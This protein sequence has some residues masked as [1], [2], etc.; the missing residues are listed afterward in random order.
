[1]PRC[2]VCVV[3]DNVETAALLCE[4][5]QSHNYDAVAVHS[6][7]EALALCAKQH[8]D[9]VLLDVCLP[10][11]DGYEVCQSLKRST[12]TEEIPVIFVTV[13]G[14]PTDVI[15]GFEMGAADY[16]TKPYNLPIVM[17]RVDAVLQKKN[18]HDKLRSEQGILLENSYTDQLTGLR[19]RRYLLERLQEEVEK[20]HRYNYPVSCAVFDV[21]QVRPLD[22]ELGPVS[23]DDLL[24]E[25]AM[26]L[27]NYSRTYDVI[28]R[29]DGALFAAI[30]PHLPLKEAC[31]YATKIM[32]EVGSTTFSDPNFP[33]EASMSA[34][35][36]ACQNGSARGAEYVLGEAMRGL[37]QAKST[38]D[39][40]LVARNLSPDA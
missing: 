34:G 29:Y 33:T 37:L 26:T 7:N 28:A 6:G 1:M 30:L 21:D 10:D 11:I 3:D 32:G 31:R 40:R 24:V 39:E 15:R 19:N 2:T 25:V 16:I 20:A 18:V 23:L 5:L 22:E 17:V 9:L 13:K 12:E 14:G 27:R 8:I 35:L 38:R 4:G 36:V